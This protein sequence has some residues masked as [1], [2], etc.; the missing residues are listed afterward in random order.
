MHGHVLRQDIIKLALLSIFFSDPLRY[1]PSFK[2]RKFGNRPW[3][4]CIYIYIYIKKNIYPYQPIHTLLT[5][6]HPTNPIPPYPIPSY[7]PNPT[8]LTQSHPSPYPIPPYK[9]N[10]TLLTQSHPTHSHPTNPIP[11]Y[12]I[13]PYQPNHTLPTQSKPT[14]M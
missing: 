10:P 6:S 5:Q 4:H 14:N 9:S 11:P 3:R 13:P 2:G 8:Q 7:Q 1:I 12:P